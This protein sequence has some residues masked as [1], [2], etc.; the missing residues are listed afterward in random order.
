MIRTRFSKLSG[1]MLEL[2]FWL[3]MPEMLESLSEGTEVAG[4]ARISWAI[5]ARSV[6]NSLQSS[7]AIQNNSGSR[8]S[9]SDFPFS[10]ASPSPVILEKYNLHFLSYR[11]R[12]LW[13]LLLGAVPSLLTISEERLSDL[14][15]DL[16]CHQEGRE[17]WQIKDLTLYIHST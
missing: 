8:I 14:D 2:L 16:L 13:S 7:W 12:S 11:S 6:W 4:T 9:S 15:G 10:L 5:D 1:K 17:A 3:R